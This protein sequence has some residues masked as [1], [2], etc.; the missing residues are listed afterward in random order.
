MTGSRDVTFDEGIACH[1]AELG[2]DELFTQ[3]HVERDDASEREKS[4]AGEEEDREKSP[5]A[6]EEDHRPVRG[7][8]SD[9]Q[10]S[11]TK[12]DWFE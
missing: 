2:G 8:S 6:E 5:A 10:V 4:P 9:P 1:G 11:S 7:G 12:P 3:K